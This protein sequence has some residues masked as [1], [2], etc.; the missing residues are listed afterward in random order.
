MSTHADTLSHPTLARAV[1]LVR[2]TTSL[3][4]PLP[5]PRGPRSAFSMTSQQSVP[6]LRPPAPPPPPPQPHAYLPSAPQQLIFVAQH[7]PGRGLQVAGFVLGLLGL[8]FSFLGAITVVLWGP[9]TIIGLILGLVGVSKAKQL[10]GA[11]RGLGRAGSAPRSD[12]PRHWHVRRLRC[13]R[14][15]SR[16]AISSSAALQG[17]MP[18]GAP[19]R[20]GRLVRRLYIAAAAAGRPRD[21]GERRCGGRRSVALQY[22]GH[23]TPSDVVSG[24]RRVTQA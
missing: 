23:D 9:L 18:R 24:P 17:N 5:F 14:R 2:P 22:L 10:P 13:P 11:P 19:A 20:T 8:L 15:D 1:R 3:P 6:V 21:T 7:R 4:H 12:R 16:S